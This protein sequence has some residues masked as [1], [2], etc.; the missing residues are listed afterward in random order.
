MVIAVQT[1]YGTVFIAMIIA[2][3]TTYS[4]YCYD[5]RCSNNIQ[6]SFYCYGY[7]SNFPLNRNKRIKSRHQRLVKYVTETLSGAVKCSSLS[8]TH[9]GYFW[10]FAPV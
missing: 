1:T 6:F 2:V 3:Q 4:I 10:L 7:M 8:T 5:Y 9:H